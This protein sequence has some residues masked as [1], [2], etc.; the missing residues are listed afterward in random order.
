[1]LAQG[2]CVDAAEVE[3]LAT[4]Q[5]SNRDLADFRRCENK[6]HM[7]RRLFQS[8]QQTVEGLPGEHVDLIDDIDFISGRNRAV[9][10]AFNQLTDI[11][12][13]GPAG[14]IHFHDIDMPVLGNGAAIVAL[15]T[16]GDGRATLA[17]D[18]CT[19][20]GAGNDTGG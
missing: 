18:T 4:G 11:I 13:T 9:A 20:Q 15:A 1:M 12:D 2:I 14:G 10:N 19:V 6:L 3:T 7:L 17:I 5:Y 8:F 16:G